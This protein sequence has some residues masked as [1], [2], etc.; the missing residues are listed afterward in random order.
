VGTWAARPSWHTAK[1]RESSGQSISYIRN[2]LL[3][4]VALTALL[5]I[6]GVEQNPGPGVEVDNTLQVLCS[7]CERNLKLGT[8]CDVCVDAGST[9]AVETSRSKWRTAGSGA[10]I[11]ADGTGFVN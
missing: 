5:V 2:M 11:D 9:T 10:V 1:G 3:C 8:Q 6:G 4:A 7:G